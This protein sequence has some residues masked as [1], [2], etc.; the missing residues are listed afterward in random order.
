MCVR[1]TGR[2]GHHVLL[3]PDR[4]VAVL[5]DRFAMTAPVP[6][7]SGSPEQR[8]QIREQGRIELTLP[9]HLT[10]VA[11]AR[12]AAPAASATCG[13]KNATEA[14][15]LILSELLSNAVKAATGSSITMLLTW[16]SRRVRIEVADGSSALPVARQAAPADEGGRG[17]WLVEVLAVRWGSFTTDRG[18]CVWAEVALPA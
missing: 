18:K 13:D 2:P 7:R 5:V 16:T 17:L 11:L 12:H 14:V 3:D 8:G 9:L 6:V 1:A 4:L 10:V 15:L